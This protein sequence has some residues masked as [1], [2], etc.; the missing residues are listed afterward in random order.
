MKKLFTLLLLLLSATYSIQAESLL[1]PV[2]LEERIRESSIVIEGKVIDQHSVYSATKG[3]VFTVNTI[4]VNGVFKGNAVMGKTIKVVTLGGTVDDFTEKVFPSLQLEIGEMG[5]FFL[6]LRNEPYDLLNPINETLYTTYSDQQGFVKYDQFLNQANDIFNV[7][8]NI[9][10]EFIQ[11]LKAKLGSNFTRNES[12]ERYLPTQNNNQRQALAI[13]G[14]S[15]SNISAGTGSVLTITGTDFGSTAGVVAFQDANNGG[16]TYNPSD[17]ITWTNTEITVTVPSGVGAL[18]GSGKGNFI[19]QLSDGSTQATSPGDSF[20]I[21]YNILNYGTNKPALKEDNGLGG[22]TM[23]YSTGTANNGVNFNADA[24]AVA[25]Y[26]R[27][28]ETWRCATL[29]NINVD[30]TTSVNQATSDDINIVTY[31]NDVQVLPNGVLGTARSYT[32]FCAGGQGLS[33]ISEIDITMRRNGTGGTTWNYGP[34]NNT[35]GKSDFESVVLHEL[36]HTHQ[37][38]HIINPGEVMHYAITVGTQNRELDQAF[39]IDAGNY[40]MN[41]STTSSCSPMTAL[42]QGGCGINA[43]L[44]KFSADK[45]SGCAPLTVQ[46]TDESSGSPTGYTW[47]F[48]DGSAASTE[49]NPSHT[50]TTAG[51]FSVKLIVENSSGVDSLIKEGLITVNVPVSLPFQQDFEPTSFPPTGFTISDDLLSGDVPWTRSAEASGFGTGT[52]SA[53]IKNGE[54]ANPVQENSIFLPPLDFSEVSNPQFKFDVAYERYYSNPTDKLT[55]YYS[56]DCGETF[57]Q[58]SYQKGYTNLF[59]SQGVKENYSNEGVFT[60]FVPE[61]N[62]WRTETISLPELGGFDNVILK[63]ARDKAASFGASNHIYIDNI[64]VEELVEAPVTAFSAD[65]LTPCVGADVQFNDLSSNNPSDYLWTFEGGTPATSTEE[66]PVVTYETEGLKMVTLKVSNSA[67]ADSITKTEYIDVQ[68]NPLASDISTTLTD[69]CSGTEILVS[70][71]G[72]FGSIIWEVSNDGS[73]FSVLPNQNNETLVY[74]PT[75]TLS[76]RLITQTDQCGNDTSNVITINVTPTPTAGFTASATQAGVDDEI[77][78]THDGDSEN[79]YIWYFGDG[80]TSMEQNPIHSYSESGKYTVS[81][82]IKN[83]TQCSDSVVKSNYVSICSPAVT[84]IISA[85][86]TLICGNDPVIVSITELSGSIKWEESQDGSSWSTIVNETSN[87]L[88][89]NFNTRVFIR[90]IAEDFPCASDTSNVIEVQQDEIPTADFTASKTVL[91]EGDFLNFTNTGDQSLEYTWDF[92]DGI[93]STTYAPTYFYSTAGT[94]TVTLNVENDNCENDII[95][96]DYIKVNPKGTGVNGENAIEFGIFPN[97]NN[98]HFTV[99][100]PKGIEI[101]SAE[102]IT[103]DGKLIAT[104]NNLDREII[105]PHSGVYFLKI[106]GKFGTSV[107]KIITQ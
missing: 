65:D 48:G 50:Y 95:K 7:Y 5:T 47:D 3:N 8:K 102:L 16:A 11:P 60:P 74:I 39:D 91:N 38:G 24:D 62:E 41:N 77:T 19:I 10:T 15:P 98:G 96:T 99:E 58:T 13:T 45:T 35:S 54:V 101:E 56:T 26:S 53:V 71:T 27:A 76:Y 46:F 86:N 1:Y 40:V 89:H 104:Y 2:S 44:V 105:T 93:S 36:G 68:A 67:G 57:T 12:I 83:E 29:V 33:Q 94:Y 22:Y 49:V 79:S 25:S 34:G 17:P 37:L 70:S 42:S 90:A 64:L 103:I 32:G 30:G 80:N 92:G 59:T 97:P 84:G 69:I 4:L 72:N 63:I 73:D 43:P 52:G 55:V 87:T 100:L 66:N 14:F 78:F 31:D 51:T 107:K 81:L 23:L 61:S 85:N 21:V 106:N 75:D 28:L 88:S 9:E 18:A 6:H 20:N 82:V